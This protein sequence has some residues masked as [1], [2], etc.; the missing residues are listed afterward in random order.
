MLTHPSQMLCKKSFSGG[1]CQN[2]LVNE[3]PCS[4][5][6]GPTG[7]SASRWYNEGYES[8]GLKPNAPAANRHYYPPQPLNPQQNDRV[9]LPRETAKT[10]PQPP[11][12][13]I[14]RSILDLENSD[15]DFS[16]RYPP[17]MSL[18]K[19]KTIGSLGDRSRSPFLANI[20][21][22]AAISRFPSLSEIE[23]GAR[24]D[25]RP[26][27]PSEDQGSSTKRWSFVKD[28][29]N[30]ERPASYPK[31]VVPARTVAEAGPGTPPK[32]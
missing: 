25:R 3:Q 4:I 32:P 29:E 8:I 14:S 15:P 19:S 31:L 28:S 10:Y 11:K 24:S 18:R 26:K 1:A 13:T 21:P 27:A 30:L 12:G 6:T 20:N 7:P 5:V 23:H 2:C 17:L 9:Q 22:E 16:T